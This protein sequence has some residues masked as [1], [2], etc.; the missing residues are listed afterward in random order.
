MFVCL[1][2]YH[3]KIFDPKNQTFSVASLS[4]NILRKS[5]YFFK[6]L[7]FSSYIFKKLFK[8]SYFEILKYLKCLLSHYIFWKNLKFFIVL[9][10]HFCDSKNSNNI[11]YVFIFYLCYTFN[12]AKTFMIFKNLL[13][14]TNSFYLFNEICIKCIMLFNCLGFSSFSSPSCFPVSYYPGL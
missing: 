12:N 6:M 9:T 11:F 1:N 10:F 13:I 2:I 14:K 8:F 4:S 3:L 5:K 7:A